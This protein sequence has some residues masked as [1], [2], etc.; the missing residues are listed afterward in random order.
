MLWLAPLLETLLGCR[1]DQD[2]EAP[3]VLAL[4]EGSATQ[5]QRITPVTFGGA[6]DDHKKSAA[7]LTAHKR[8][9]KPWVWETVVQCVA[10]LAEGRCRCCVN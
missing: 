3:R 7:P 9:Q 8:L 6:D 4:G 1:V 5:C 2:P 10:A